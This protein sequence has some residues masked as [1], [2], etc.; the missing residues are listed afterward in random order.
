MLESFQGLDCVQGVYM[1]WFYSLGHSPH[2]IWKVHH[3][4][5]FGSW[6]NIILETFIIL[7]FVTIGI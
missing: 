7:L 1:V 6:T 3:S 4:Y 5:Q 2:R